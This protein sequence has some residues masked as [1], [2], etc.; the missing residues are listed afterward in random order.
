MFDM[1]L[2]EMLSS[3]AFAI[4]QKAVDDYPDRYQTL[5]DTFKAT[6]D[7]PELVKAYVATGGAPEYLSYGSPEECKDFMKAMLEL[8]EK[9]KSLIAGA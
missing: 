1:N 5:I 8:G 4:Q 2:P 9:Y 6:F 3:R 7:D